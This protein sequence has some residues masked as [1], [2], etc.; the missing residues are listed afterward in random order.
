MGGGLQRGTAM[1]GGPNLNFMHAVLR[2][3]RPHCTP[4]PLCYPHS[5]TSLSCFSM[6]CGFTR[7]STAWKLI[8]WNGESRADPLKKEGGADLHFASCFQCADFSAVHKPT[9]GW[10]INTYFWFKL[11]LSGIIRRKITSDDILA[12]NRLF[13]ALVFLLIDETRC[14][15][16]TEFDGTKKQTPLFLVLVSEC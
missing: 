12:Y 4:L 14:N 10:F 8:W 13:F 3:N 16:F 7:G 1:L 5:L 9:K 15:D 6:T 2:I 11:G